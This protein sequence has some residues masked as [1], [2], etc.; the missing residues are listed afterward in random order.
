MALETKNSDLSARVILLLNCS[1]SH[2]GNV[3]HQDNK[4]SNV[5]C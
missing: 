1:K 2:G 3:G 5:Q 4:T